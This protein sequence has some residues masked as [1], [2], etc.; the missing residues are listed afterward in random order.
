MRKVRILPNHRGPNRNYLPGQVLT[1]DDQRAAILV[2]TGHAEYADLP[3]ES[4]MPETPEEE[5]I[6]KG[7][8]AMGGKR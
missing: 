2:E 8:A 4:G 3:T 6:P 5:P 1:V 7:R